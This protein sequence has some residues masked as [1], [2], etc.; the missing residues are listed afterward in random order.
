MGLKENWPLFSLLVVMSAFVGAMVGFERSLLP[1]LTQHWSIG[2]LEAGL[3]M[4]MSFGV[5]KATANLLTGHLMQR[6]GRKPTLVLGWFIA[7]CSPIILWWAPSNALILLANLTL[8]FSQG[9]T[10]SATVMMKI[11]LVGPKNRGTA[12]GFNE[13]AGYVAVGAAA[14]LGAWYFD[15]WGQIGFILQAA[16]VLATLA[17][18]LSIVV[19][20]E[21]RPWADLEGRQASESDEN[22]KESVFRTTSFSNRALRNFTWA[23]VANNANDGVLWAVLPTVV[24]A[25]GGSSTQLGVLTGIHAASWGIGQLLTGPLSNNTGS[26]RPLILYGML[27][28]SLGLFAL[29]GFLNAWWPYL[30]IGLGTAL[31]Y[32]TLLVGVSHYSHPA[33]R[34]KAMATYRFWRDMGYVL[35]GL[36]G[37]LAVQLGRPWW[38]FGAVA[39][40]TAYAG[41]SFYRG[42][43]SSHDRT[44]SPKNTAPN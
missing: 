11:D 13:S 24:L 20:V 15:K 27:L 9:L 37:F 4:V 42:V 22:L 10:W 33:W 21:T 31:V 34:P 6:Y 23:G 19:V 43:P 14:A 32:P 28:Q 7:L 18:F 41:I 26:F 30:L 5:S 39:V 40:I 35:G 17:L 29:Y 1:E 36:V 3:L 12:M 8:G 16:L 38:T 25:A 44:H 2:S